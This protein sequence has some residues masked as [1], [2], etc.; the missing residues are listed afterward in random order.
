M[1]RFK[2]VAGDLIKNFEKDE[3]D[4][5]VHGCN[6]FHIMGAGIANQISLK[7]PQAFAA[8]KQ[9]DCGSMF[10]LGTLTIADTSNGKIVNAYTQFLP[11]ANF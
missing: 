6:C 11:G 8:D 4:A 5:I 3:Y 9:S 1:T 2:E 7:Y 10:K